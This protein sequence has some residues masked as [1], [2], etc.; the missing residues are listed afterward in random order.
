MYDL[1]KRDIGQIKRQQE[2]DIV[3]FG[4]L[5]KRE[6]VKKGYFTVRLTV[7]VRAGH[8]VADF[9]GTAFFNSDLTNLVYFGTY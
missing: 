3:K 8:A 2:E 6:G 1:H 7:S 9:V 5:L 4:F